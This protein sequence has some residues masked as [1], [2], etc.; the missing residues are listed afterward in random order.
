MKTY[1]TITKSILENTPVWVFDKLDG[2]NLRAEWS[3]KRG[4]YKFGSRTRLIDASE[5][6]LGKGIGLFLEKY[7]EDLIRV[8]KF[9]KWKRVVVF[10]EFWGPNSFAGSHDP[11]DKMGVTLFDVSRDNKGILNPKEFLR[12][13]GDLDHPAL[14]YQGEIT[15]EFVESVQLGTLEGMTFEGV[16]CKGYEVSPGLPLMFKIK[17]S[18]WISKLRDRC[19]GD[20]SL[21]DSL[22]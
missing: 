2:S 17:N 8:F 15:P 18:N 12:L 19:A 6:I 14:L 9:Q 11:N 1:P 4:F 20:E 13:F 7:S 21:F 16:V 22:S 10:F 3:A 5:P